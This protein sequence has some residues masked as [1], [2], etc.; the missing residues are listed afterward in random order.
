MQKAFSLASRDSA[1]SLNCLTMQY[2]QTTPKVYFT[3][4]I[5]ELLNVLHQE[6]GEDA[7]LRQQ[8]SAESKVIEMQRFMCRSRCLTCMIHF[9]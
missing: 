2:L 6:L 1:K 8:L 5:V 9:Q 4:I 3:F 7:L